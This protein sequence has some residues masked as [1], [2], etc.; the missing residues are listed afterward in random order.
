MQ[1]IYCLEEAEKKLVAYERWEQEAAR[2]TLQEVFG[3]VFVYVLDPAH[4][5]NQPHHRL[6]PQCYED[7]KKSI[8]QWR[9]GGM[10]GPIAF[11]SRCAFQVVTGPATNPYGW[12]NNA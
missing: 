3:G 4:A 5:A 10:S 2:Y 11:C 1:N 6:C 7:S 8:L 9:D 12:L